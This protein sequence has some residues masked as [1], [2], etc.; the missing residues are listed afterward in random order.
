M[1]PPALVSS[2]IEVPTSSIYTL[3]NPKEQTRPP[4][5]VF[6]VPRIEQ[7]D[8]LDLSIPKL[9]LMLYQQPCRSASIRRTQD[10][11]AF[12]AINVEC[13]ARPS[14]PL[15]QAMFHQDL[16]ENSVCRDIL[17]SESDNILQECW[18]DSRV[19]IGRDVLKKSDVGPVHQRRYF[20]DYFVLEWSHM[21]GGAVIMRYEYA[22]VMVAHLSETSVGC[23]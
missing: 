18:R 22:F 21:R 8:L 23:L 5:N 15:C 14:V 1:I 17:D 7:G 9:L 10:R 11:A 4:I 2:D 20:G 12:F 16:A 6:L 3:S 13:D 19:W